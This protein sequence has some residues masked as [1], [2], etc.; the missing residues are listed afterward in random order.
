L[1]KLPLFP[2]RTFDPNFGQNIM[3][4][5]PQFGRMVGFRDFYPTKS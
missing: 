2:N 5:V 3:P 1:K 4:N